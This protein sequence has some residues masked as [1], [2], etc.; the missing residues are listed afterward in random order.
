MQ[1]AASVPFPLIV[2]PYGIHGSVDRS[3]AVRAALLLCLLV[4]EGF[5]P[6]RLQV[7]A[8]PFTPGASSIFLHRSI[9]CGMIK[10]DGKLVSY[11][12]WFSNCR[13]YKIIL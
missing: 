5:A 8:R 12:M 4:L 10:V 3:P 13:S 11:S 1:P 7:P 6:S 2:E 9:G